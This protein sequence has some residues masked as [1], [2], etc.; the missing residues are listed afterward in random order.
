MINKRICSRLTPLTLVGG[1]FENMVVMEAFK[2]RLNRGAMDDLYFMRTRHGVQAATPARTDRCFVFVAVAPFA[3]LLNW[4]LNL[5]AGYFHIFIFPVLR[6]FR[7]LLRCSTYS[8]AP[9][10]R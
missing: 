5:D 9:P 4:I 10:L 6:Y 8:A 7:K 3:Q 2:H 1:I